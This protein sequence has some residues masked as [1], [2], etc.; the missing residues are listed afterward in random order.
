M[1]SDP[2]KLDCKKL[3]QVGSNHCTYHSQEFTL[4][5][6]YAIRC[7]W[8]R[9]NLK[10]SN[11]SFISDQD[12]QPDRLHVY[13]FMHSWP[14]DIHPLCLMRVVRAGYHSIKAYCNHASLK[15][16]GEHWNRCHES[17]IELK[18]LWR[19]FDLQSCCFHCLQQTHAYIIMFF[20][21]L[22]WSKNSQIRSLKEYH[23]WSKLEL[24]NV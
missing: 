23:Q 22:N 5:M 1:I 21:P 18:S 7:I 24:R 10:R 19:S 6:R 14:S 17:K 3:H 15:C 4:I 9:Y 13:V 11:S 2:T 16:R 20:L 8:L 12:I